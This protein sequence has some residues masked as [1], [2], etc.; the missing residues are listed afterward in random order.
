MSVI[1]ICTVDRNRPGSAA[2]ASAARAPRLPLLAIAFSRA[3]RDETIASSLIDNSAVDEDQ[4]QDEDEVEPGEREQS[5][6]HAG[7]PVHC[8]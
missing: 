2:S 4:R 6:G 8:R 3:S 5:V 7:R 1:P